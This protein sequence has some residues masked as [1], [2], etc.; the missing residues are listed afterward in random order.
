[1]TDEPS[2]TPRAPWHL[3]LV[4]VLGTILLLSRRRLAAPVLEASFLSLIVASFHNFVLADGAA[5]MGTTGTVFSVLIFIV[6]LGLWLYARA[7]GQR[8]VL[9]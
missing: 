3:W 6:S 2:P 7:M 4:G 5:I 8:G 9:A 1:M